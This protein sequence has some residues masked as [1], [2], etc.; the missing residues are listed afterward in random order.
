[1]SFCISKA[2]SGWVLL[3]EVSAAFLSGQGWAGSEETWGRRKPKDKM[4]LQLKKIIASKINVLMQGRDLKFIALGAHL[5][6]CPL[7]VLRMGGH[8]MALSWPPWHVAAS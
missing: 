1:M 2:S 4:L 6:F 3:V 8:H 7:T 5:Q